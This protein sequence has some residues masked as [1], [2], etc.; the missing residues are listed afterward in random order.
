MRI[1]LLLLIFFYSS[2]GAQTIEIK[3]MYSLAIRDSFIVRIK[4]PAGYDPE[5]SYHHIYTADGG[6]KL[7]NYIIGTSESWKADIPPNCIIITIAHTG[8]WHM[9]RRRD[10]LPSDAGGYSNKEFGQAQAFYQFLKNSI[11][12]YVSV[13][14]KKPVSTAFI[15]HSFS[16]LFCLYLLF[17]DDRLF[18]KHYAISPSVWANDEE[19]LKIEK[20][21][22]EK[23]KRLPANISLQ[24][25][26]LEIF[27]KV[28][29]ST[30]EFR[31]ITAARKYA[32]YTVRF[33]TVNN[34]NHYSIIK[35]GVDKILQEF[36]N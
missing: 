5:K 27:N 25:G 14:F 23:K 30:K 32:G 8:D 19:L 6:I 10:F 26:G 1:A 11:I 2:A 9:K 16:G 24:A 4:T 3:T 36:R 13:T 22:F 7:G 18:D 34:A 35:P 21:F 20:R 28:L 31:T 29:S 17:Q 12:P 33:S 15:G